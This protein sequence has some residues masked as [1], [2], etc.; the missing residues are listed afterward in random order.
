M[1]EL[2]LNNNYWIKVNNNKTRKMITNKPKKIIKALG[3]KKTLWNLVIIIIIKGN[4]PTI[5]LNSPIKDKP[6]T[7]MPLID[8]MYSM[9][10][11]K[12]KIKAFTA[13]RTPLDKIILMGF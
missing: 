7:G 5:N 1:I 8:W 2:K 6:P 3:K 9:I 13:N 4:I 10:V 11:V 12:N